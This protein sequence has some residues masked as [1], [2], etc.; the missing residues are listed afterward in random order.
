MGN[1]E[2]GAVL[3]MLHDAFVPFSHSANVAAAALLALWLNT[4]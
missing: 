4:G 3:V 1:S 2:D